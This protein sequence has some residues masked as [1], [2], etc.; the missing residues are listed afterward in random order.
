MPLVVQ[1]QDDATRQTIR[2]AMNARMER[3]RTSQGYE[4]P[5]PA[6]LYAGRKP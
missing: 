2:E 3:F 6:I 5:M 4:V 1:A